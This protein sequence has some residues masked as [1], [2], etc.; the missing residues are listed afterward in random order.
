M[1]S[2]V[3]S[4]PFDKAKQ[5]FSINVFKRLCDI[6][7]CTY[8]YTGIADP[9]ET[10]VAASIA[11]QAYFEGRRIGREDMERCIEFWRS[12]VSEMHNLGN[13]IMK[14]DVMCEPLSIPCFLW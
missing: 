1:V 10:S 8:R 2:L 11:L 4:S 7:F 14:R 13:P 5:V 6:W 9:E 12:H 3:L